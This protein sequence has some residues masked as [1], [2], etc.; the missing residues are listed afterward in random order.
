M[1]ARSK[2]KGSR[3]GSAT[4]ARDDERREGGRERLGK[5]IRFSSSL[6]VGVAAAVYTP[7][8]IATR[9]PP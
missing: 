4:G 9:L 5:K 7:S 1:I 3:R 8:L 6:E 2:D